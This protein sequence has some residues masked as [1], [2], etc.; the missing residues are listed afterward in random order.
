MRIFGA[1]LLFSAWFFSTA[2]INTDRPTQSASAI[3]LPKGAIQLEAGFLSE[4]P[5]SRVD[6]YNV[7]YLNALL[8]AGLF[9]G[10]ELRLSQNYVGMRINGDGSNGL[11]PTTIGTKVHLFEENSGI[12][13][14]SVIG[15]VTFANGTDQFQPDKSIQELRFNFQNAISD[16]VGLGY[17]L[18]GIWDGFETIGLYSVVL[19]ISVAPTLAFF[20]EPY[21]FIAKNTPHDGRFNTGLIYAGSDNFQLDI[22]VGNGLT[23]R[24]PD[25]FLSVGIAAHF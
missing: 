12:P 20:L 23:K 10:V 19:G 21:G 25:Y 15:Q 8:R 6:Q 3:V 9:D 2:Q 4:R 14:I 5:L 1:F 11:S 7:Q 13:Q 16:N 17:N 18:G 24:A 22:S